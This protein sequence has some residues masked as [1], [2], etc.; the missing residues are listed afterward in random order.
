MMRPVMSS[1]SLC[2]TAPGGG[3]DDDALGFNRRS[4]VRARS[5]RSWRR[6]QVLGESDAIFSALRLRQLVERDQRRDAIGYLSRFVPPLDTRRPPLSVEAEVLHRFLGMQ[7]VLACIVAG[8][9][10]SDIYSQYLS[11]H[12]T[13]PH[14]AIRIRSIVLSILYAR[15]QV[16]ASIDWERVRYKAA[17]IVH[18]LAYRTPEFKDLIYMPGSQVKPHNVLP[19]GFG[20]RRR[21]HPKKPSARPRASALAKV[22]LGQ[23]RSL[24]AISGPSQESCDELPVSNKAMDWVADIVDECLKAGMR[25]E[26]HQTA[27]CSLTSGC[28][29]SGI[30]SMAN[31]ACTDAIAA[32]VSQ[33]MFGSL[34]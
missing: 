11:H 23:R 32:L 31:A 8:G 22:Y 28:G 27:F 33:T 30:G 17:E 10:E 20:F 25:P 26:F 29:N 34:L 5:T 1:S 4:V 24:P 16:R 9:K 18:D 21:C 19:V 7:G 12:R 3:V 13:V 6:A 15:Q 14:G 2:A